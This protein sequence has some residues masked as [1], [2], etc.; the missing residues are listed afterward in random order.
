M[1]VT[2]V[3]LRPVAPATRFRTIAGILLLILAGLALA[4]GGAAK[5]RPQL[6]QSGIQFRTVQAGEGPFITMN[7]AALIE[8]TGTFDSGEV[9]DSTEGKGPAP[10]SPQGVIP[11]FAEALQKMQKGGHYKFRLPP[12]LAYGSSPPPGFPAD[13][14]LNF[15]VRVLQVAPG[16]AA[17]LG[18][19]GGQPQR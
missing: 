18:A 17:M 2:A 6:T 7:D 19:G 4:W 8:Y 5:L 10:M 15:D 16:A 3:P 1:S 12:E 9:F 14:A 13:A 11:G